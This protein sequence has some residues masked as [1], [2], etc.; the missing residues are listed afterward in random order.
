MTRGLFGLGAALALALAVAFM[1]ASPARAYCIGGM[2]C[3]DTASFVRAD[4]LNFSCQSLW[5]MRNQ[6]FKENGYCFQ[7]D[8]ARNFFGNG[9]C[10]TSNQA[11]ARSNMNRFER[12]NVDEIVGV[13]RALSC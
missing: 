2:G 9:G 13:E 4:L 8:R 10:W 12:G 11:E 1:P 5:E 6:I 7:T 3:S